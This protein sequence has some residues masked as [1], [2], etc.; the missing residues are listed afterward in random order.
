VKLSKHTQTIKVEKKVG[1][2]QTMNNSEGFVS[3]IATKKTALEPNVD[4]ML[5]LGAPLRIVSESGYACLV[6]LIHQFVY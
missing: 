5:I 3:S 1:A 2:S 6:S 4:G